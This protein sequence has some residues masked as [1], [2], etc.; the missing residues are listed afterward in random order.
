M[1]SNGLH[2]QTFQSNGSSEFE[3]HIACPE[4]GSSDGNSLYTDGHTYC[5][6][7]HTHRHSTE[8]QFTTT[9]TNDFRFKG[10]AERLQS[11]G[12]SEATCQKYKIFRD[13]NTLRF[14]YFTRDGVVQGCKVK[15]KLKEFTYE[16]STPGTLFGQHLFPSTG[17][18]VVIT[19]GELDA[20]SCSEA[21]PGWPMVSLPSG[22]AAAK[23]SVQQ[24]LD[25]LQGYEEIVLFFDNDSAGRKATE[26][27]SSVLPPG[28]V[29]IAF[30][31]SDYKDASDALIANDSEAI[32]RGIW[33]E[34]P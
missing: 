32:R 5:F 3:R 14:H 15:T 23:K 22:A 21:M 33:D 11:R 4:C 27:A 24:N 19:E 17:K 9:L 8:Q 18:R 29:K 1:I 31:P 26:E 16:G 34:R 30:L 13:G 28:K 12:I 7:C 10:S 25:W 2:S 20:A 6:V